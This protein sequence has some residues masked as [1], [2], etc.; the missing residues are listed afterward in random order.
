MKLIQMESWSN[1][2]PLRYSTTPRM[3]IRA[4]LLSLS[5]FAGL[6]A[7]T[8]AVHKANESKSNV[9]ASSLASYL[10]RVRAEDSNIQ[11]APGSIWIDSGRLTRMVTD[12]RAMR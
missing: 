10:E 6:E 9:A 2:D 11:A 1:I 8:I 5:A 4:L 7:Q 12:V 3:L